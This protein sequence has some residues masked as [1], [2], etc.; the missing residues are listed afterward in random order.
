MSEYVKLQRSDHRN[1]VVRHKSKVADPHHID[2]DPDSSF[3]FNA[4]SCR[5]YIFMQIRKRILHRR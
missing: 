3:H 1:V 5:L 2:A 4:N